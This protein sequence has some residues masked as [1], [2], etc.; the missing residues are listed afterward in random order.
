MENKNNFFSFCIQDKEKKG[1]KE[2][3]KKIQ[4][5]QKRKNKNNLNKSK[6]K[7]DKKKSRIDRLANRMKPELN[8]IQLPLG[9]KL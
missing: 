5:Q 7:K 6:K 2:N 4:Q 9:L 8:D 1:G 3:K